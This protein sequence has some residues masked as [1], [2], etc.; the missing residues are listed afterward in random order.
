MIM[1]EIL[2]I[3]GFGIAGISGFLM[4]I[5][6]LFKMLIGEY[7]LPEDLNAA[8]HSMSFSIVSMIIL[9]SL[10]FRAFTHTEY[11][12]NLIPV[13]GQSSS[14]GFSISK[15]YENLIGKNA[16]TVTVLR[17]SGRVDIEGKIY[18]AMSTG[19]YIESGEK[20]MVSSTDE[21]QLVVK[22]V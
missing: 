5:Y 17:P 22:K 9:G 15:G 6:S 3:P 2:I 18:Q 21:N 12:K 1:M 11:Y 13:S 19:D 16:I 14:D 7:P 8:M 20:V 4:I 10:I